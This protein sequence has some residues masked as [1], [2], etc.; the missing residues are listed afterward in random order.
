MHPDT[1]VDPPKSYSI[2]NLV[3]AGLLVMVL[4]AAIWRMW[5][6]GMFIEAT[7]HP[8]VGNPLSDVAFEPLLNTQAKVTTSQLRGKPVL[9]N[10]WG[11]WC[12][13]C[14]QEF[15]ELSALEK[16][17]RPRADVVFLLVSSDGG[18]GQTPQ[19]LAADSQLVLDQNR[20]TAAIYYDP[21]DQVRSAIVNSARLDQ[22]GYP[23][24]LILD[25]AG[26]IRGVWTG[27][28]DYA[29]DEMELLLQRLLA[30]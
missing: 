30:E 16:K 22:F 2:S 21:Q 20:S 6:P 25:K 29:V 8:G 15:P 9:I 5:N 26:I 12:G 10:M 14:R 18:G 23:T 19:E 28:T 3:I 7:A 1:Q 27:F 11:P 17:H 24:T 13:P 4:G